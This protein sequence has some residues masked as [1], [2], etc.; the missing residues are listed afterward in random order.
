MLKYLLYLIFLLTAGAIA[1]TTG[2]VDVSIKEIFK[3]L[4]GDGD[5]M[6]SQ[7]ILN[8]RLPR[9]LVT[10]LCGA[11]LA[12]SGAI[13]QGVMRNPL[14]SPNIIGVSAGAGIGGMAVLILLPEFIWLVTPV[15]FGSALLTTLIIY[16]IAWRGGAE[17]LRLILSGV[18]V[19]AFIGSGISSLLI[20]FPDR[21]HNVVGFMVGGF[22]TASWNEFRM[23]M[24]YIVPA[25]LVALI[26]AGRLN[27]LGLGDDSA[28]NLGLRVELN[29][30]IFISTA[31]MLAAAAVS[32]A[33]LLGFVGLIVPHGTRFISG[34]DNRN[35]IP[36]SAV[37]GAGLLILCD[38]LARVALA[39]VELPVGVI[40]SFLGAPFFL[41]LLRYRFRHGN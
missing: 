2:A 23:S 6:L 25:L 19:S 34:A 7:I 20:F 24:P 16:F 22:G 14:A 29:R 5:R 21:V 28:S 17:P 8:I 36:A 3:I 39:P 32:V 13:L 33:G 4:S 10:G 38:T 35:L 1:L 31:S 12:T 30:F 41:Y 15:A 27:I 40:T 9:I 18:A 11:A 37:F 26:M